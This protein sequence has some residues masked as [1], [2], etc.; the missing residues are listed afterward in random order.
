MATKHTVLFLS[1]FAVVA[2]KPQTTCIVLTSKKQ[3]LFSLGK[4]WHRCSW[5]IDHLPPSSETRTQFLPTFITWLLTLPSS[6][7]DHYALGLEESPWLLLKFLWPNLVVWLW[8]T[9]KKVGTLSGYLSMKRWFRCR[10]QPAILW[11]PHVKESENGTNCFLPPIFGFSHLKNLPCFKHSRERFA[12]W[13]SNLAE[14]WNKIHLT[15]SSVS[16]QHKS[17]SV[18]RNLCFCQ[19][20]KAK[21]PPQNQPNKGHTLVVDALMTG[22]WKCVWG[23]RHYPSE[24]ARRAEVNKAALVCSGDIWS[25]EGMKHSTH[26][27]GEDLCRLTTITTTIQ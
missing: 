17:I 7:S 1:I 26:L 13:S 10:K 16:L 21:P 12:L 8:S 5:T 23:P 24:D 25:S 18:P 15:Q 19:V 20:N 27:A 11:H 2:N 6:M 22:T 9:R 14:Y 4:V 3:F